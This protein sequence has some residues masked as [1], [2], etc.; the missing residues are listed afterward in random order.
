MVTISFSSELLMLL[1][2]Q[3]PA[4]KRIPAARLRKYHALRLISKNIPMRPT[5]SS[6]RVPLE[7]YAS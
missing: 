1:A 7:N 5:R 2:Y 3:R 4:V 6:V